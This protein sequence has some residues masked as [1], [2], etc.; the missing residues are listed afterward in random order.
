[1]E[2]R[3]PG[4]AAAPPA[5]PLTH[6]TAP[7]PPPASSS[8]LPGS[9]RG[10]PRSPRQPENPQPIARRSSASRS[11]ASRLSSA[12]QRRRGG[13]GGPAA[14]RPPP[15]HPPAAEPRAPSAA[16]EHRAAFRSDP[17]RSA[18][19]PPSA[20]R[21]RRPPA[22]PPFP[23]LNPS[24]ASALRGAA[25]GME[26]SGPVG[27]PEPGRCSGSGAAPTRSPKGCPPLGRMRLLEHQH[28]RVGEVELRAASPA[29]RLLGL[30]LPSAPGGGE[31]RLLVSVPKPEL[32]TRSA[33][34]SAG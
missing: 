16:A 28:A 29:P 1:M 19:L 22:P 21:R 20:R 18:P 27:A 25:P 33:P 26:T 31:R 34:R 30:S 10:N 13:R 2:P 15:R 11:S 17:I 24:S 7:S 12:R 6:R 8:G 23:A 4:T 32:G 14:L 9:R 3:T 5:R